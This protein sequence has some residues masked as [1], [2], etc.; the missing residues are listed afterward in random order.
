MPRPPI[1]IYGSYR[2]AGGNVR[3][4]GK[5]DIRRRLLIGLVVLDTPY[6]SITRSAFC[7]TGVGGWSSEPSSC[8]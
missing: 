8:L 4:G 5:A 6:Q 7:G 1:E 2:L 3:F